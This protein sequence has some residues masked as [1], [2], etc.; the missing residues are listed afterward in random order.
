MAVLFS[1]MT[2]RLAKVCECV[3]ECMCLLFIQKEAHVQR[4][5]EE[6]NLVTRTTYE[7]LLRFLETG[8]KDI[9]LSIVG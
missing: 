5:T 2:K 1:Y 6:G 8:E 9:A 7:A 3:Q 4:D